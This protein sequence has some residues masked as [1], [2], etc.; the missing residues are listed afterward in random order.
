MVAGEIEAPARVVGRTAAG[1][2]P[3]QVEA[4]AD[5]VRAAGVGQHVRHLERRVELIPVRAAAAEPAEV[6]D[7]D[8]RDA[9]VAVP[10]V[11]VEARNAQVGPASGGRSRRRIQRVEVDAVIADPEVVVQGRR[12]RVRVGDQRVLVDAR[13]RRPGDGNR[14]DDCCC[15]CRASCSGPTA[16]P[17]CRGSGRRGSAAGRRCP[18]SRPGPGSWWPVP[19]RFGRRIVLR[20]SSARSATA[21]TRE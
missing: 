1:G 15:S 6:A 3:A 8:A 7:V 2:Q 9:R 10:D 12:Q 17:C 19:G 14:A 13:L 11:A 20:G 18:C 4:G 5:V 21:A 16:G